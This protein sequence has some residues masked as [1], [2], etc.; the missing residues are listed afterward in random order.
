[1]GQIEETSFFGFAETRF[2]VTPAAVSTALG[3]VESPD[4]PL[5]ESGFEF[6]VELISG[7]VAQIQ[8]PENRSVPDHETTDNAQ[9]GAYSYLNAS[10]GKIRAADHDG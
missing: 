6:S 1:L 4:D 10:A 5:V 2:G 8:S 7:V 9:A 3:A